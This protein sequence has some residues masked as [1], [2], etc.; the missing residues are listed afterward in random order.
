MVEGEIRCASAVERFL[1]RHF[2]LALRKTGADALPR[3]TGGSPGEC[4]SGG[5]SHGTVPAHYTQRIVP[6]AGT[7]EQCAAARR[8]LRHTTIAL[9]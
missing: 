5:F 4:N 2:R 6:A 3:E 8:V 9:Y 7:G 1:E